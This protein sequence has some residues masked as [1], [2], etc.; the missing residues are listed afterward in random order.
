[1]NIHDIYNLFLPY[2]RKK[3]KRLFHQ[4]IR[5]KPTQRILDVGGYHDFWFSMD[6]ANPVTC[7]NLNVPHTSEPLPAQFTYIRADARYLPY[8]DAEFEVIFSNS[9][10]EHLG[11]YNNQKDFA[12]EIRRVGKSYWVETPNRWFPVEPHFITPFI[13]YLPV[14]IQKSLL[15]FTVWGFVIRPTKAQVSSYLSEIRLLTENEMRELFPE[16]KIYVERFLG[17]KK[18]FIAVKIGAA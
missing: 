5:L 1:M 13:H 7:L 15:R 17:F 9:V 2:F 6:C 10:I 16:A 8:R 12:N 4:L 14:R 3:R 11:T 18:S